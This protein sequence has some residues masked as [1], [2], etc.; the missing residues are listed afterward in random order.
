[1]WPGCVEIKH[2]RTIGG[3]R[4]SLSLGVHD[5]YD[6]DVREA[7]C[8]FCNWTYVS[9]ASAYWELKPTG[10]PNE[11]HIV[12]HKQISERLSEV[13]GYLMAFPKIT[14]EEADEEEEEEEEEH[15]FAAA[16]GNE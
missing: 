6:A 3:M 4:N 5:F 14:N 11:F 13:T 15:V 10:R 7:R 12:V 2:T 9:W 1:M 8:Y 16:S